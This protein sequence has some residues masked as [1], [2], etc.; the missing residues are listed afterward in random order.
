MLEILI[1]NNNVSNPNYDYL[2]TKYNS[3][4]SSEF[5]RRNTFYYCQRKQSVVN[6]VLKKQSVVI[7]LVAT[8]ELGKELEDVIN[9]RNNILE[10]ILNVAPLKHL[11]N[12]YHK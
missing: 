6:I 2:M 8:D 9:R 10:K 12:M 4:Y 5:V 11:R 7:M 3:N 1:S